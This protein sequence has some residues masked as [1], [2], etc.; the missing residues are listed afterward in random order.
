MGKFFRVNQNLYTSYSQKNVTLA[1]GKING[2][3]QLAVEL[4]LTNMTT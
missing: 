3:T 2:E 1:N 4:A